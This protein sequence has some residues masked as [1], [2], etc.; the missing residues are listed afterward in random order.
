MA[1]RK[2][3]IPLVLNHAKKG[4]VMT[5]GIEGQGEQTQLVVPFVR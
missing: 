5:W 3:V 1:N 4:D 2:S